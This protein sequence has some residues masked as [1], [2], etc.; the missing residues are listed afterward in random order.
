MEEAK[1]LIGKFLG[2]ACKEVG[3]TLADHVRLFRLKRQIAILRKEVQLT[4]AQNQDASRLA[5]LDSIS[6]LVDALRKSGSN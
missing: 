6:D 2:P 3:E 4:Y 1:G 5:S